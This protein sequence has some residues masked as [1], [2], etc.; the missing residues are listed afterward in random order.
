MTTRRY[1]FREHHRVVIAT[2]LSHPTAPTVAE[3]DAAIDITCELTTD[4]LNIPRDTNGVDASP[5]RGRLEVERPATYST[6]GAGLKGYRAGQGDTELLWP[7]A[8]FNT[9]AWLVIRRGLPFTLA[10]L[11]E[12]VVEVCRFRFGQRVTAPTADNAPVTFTVPLFISDDT[13]SAVVFA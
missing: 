2:S 5:W 9:E 10:W 1:P 6:S 11:P 13:D 7:L 12:Q 8:V 3:L 4:G